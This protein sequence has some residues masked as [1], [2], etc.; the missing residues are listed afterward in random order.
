MVG[1]VTSFVL[2]GALLMNVSPAGVADAAGTPIRT[3]SVIS[4]AMQVLPTSGP[5]G[6]V[7]KVRAMGLPVSRIC[8]RL[9]A[10]KDSAGKVTYLKNLP[11]TSYFKTTAKI[12]VRAALGPGSVY[13]QDAQGVPPHCFGGFVAA[14]A[15]FTVT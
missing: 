1:R 8:S 12:P 13:V 14:A 3:P 10:F 4:A 5:G 9:L 15:S 11:V 7:I 2:A 6:T